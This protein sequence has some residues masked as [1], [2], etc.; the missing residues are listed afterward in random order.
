M[1]EVLKSVMESPALISLTIAFFITSA[2]T[3]FDKRLT[4]AQRRGELPADQHTLPDWV[5]VIGWIHWGIGLTLLILNWK[6]ALGIFILK[7]VLSVLPVL[8][9]AGNL[10]M[11]PFRPRTLARTTPATEPKPIPFMLWVQQQEE[12]ISVQDALDRYIA[13]YGSAV[14]PPGVP[15]ALARQRAEV[16][17]LEEFMAVLGDSASTEFNSLLFQKRAALASREQTF[18]MTQELDEL[19]RELERSDPPSSPPAG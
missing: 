13:Q 4:Q 1:S 18:K 14:P 16:S 10:I 17:L 19:R 9:T 8:E 6:Y 5:G 2:I 11:S 7:F 3:T 12:D 15:E